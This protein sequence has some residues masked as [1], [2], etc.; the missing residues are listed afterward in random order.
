MTAKLQLYLFNF[1]FTN[2]KKCSLKFMICYLL[3][4]CAK[5]VKQM[6]PVILKYF[7]WRNEIPQIIRL[8]SLLSAF[9]FV[10]STGIITKKFKINKTVLLSIFIISYVH[11]DHHNSY[12]MRHVRV[13]CAKRVEF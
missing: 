12:L 5:I 13:F 3:V 9:I 6:R 7:H 1:S 4:T 11:G 10:S 8:I 2:P